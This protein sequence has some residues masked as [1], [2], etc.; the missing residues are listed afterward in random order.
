MA[1]E[2][3]LY[4][5]CG[6][7]HLVFRVRGVVV[8]RM[9]VGGLGLARFVSVVGPSVARNMCR[10]GAC[11]IF[12]SVNSFNEMKLKNVQYLGRWHNGSS[13][14]S[15]LFLA[16]V[17]MNIQQRDEEEKPLHHVTGCRGKAAR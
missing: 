6:N 13:P 14:Q 4:G 9:G 5:R 15:S 10:G 11:I 3:G 17:E 7:P 16:V 1:R 2:G 8:G 12:W